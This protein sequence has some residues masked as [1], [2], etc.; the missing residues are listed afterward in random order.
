[1]KK[2]IFTM[3][4]QIFTLIELLVVIAIIAILAG[5]LMPALSKAREQ[6]Y[7]ISCT[8]NLKQM[9]ID[10]VSYTYDNQDFFP[11]ALDS[12]NYSPSF[13]WYTRIQASGYLKNF[14]T[15]CSVTYPNG[16]GGKSLKCPKLVPS[17]GSDWN[18]MVNGTTFGESTTYKNIRKLQ[19]ITKPSSRCWSSEPASNYAG[20]FTGL[21]DNYLDL[22]TPGGLGDGRR[23]QNSVNVLYVDA[24]AGNLLQKLLPIGIDA[25]GKY[26]ELWGTNTN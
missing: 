11:M 10:F 18:Y 6:G 9:G 2:Q 5:M 13:Y 14:Y 1:M 22:T 8:N 20:G 17:G 25:R 23:H 3:K 24:H 15:Y 12:I 16:A 26:S 19:T 7:K 4:K 21:N